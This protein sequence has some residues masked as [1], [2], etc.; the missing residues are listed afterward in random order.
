MEKLGVGGAASDDAAPPGERGL[1]CRTEV[2]Q[3]RTTLDSVYLKKNDSRWKLAYGKGLSI[4]YVALWCET[5]PYIR[6]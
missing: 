6:V 3:R 5:A 4:P 2:G 1:N